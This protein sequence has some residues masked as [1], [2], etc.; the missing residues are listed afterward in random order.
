[1]LCIPDRYKTF[2]SS[3]KFIDLF[4]GIGG[5][6]ISLES[7][8][9][10][11]VFSSDINKHA[12]H[13]YKE[14]FGDEPSGDITKIDAKDIPRHD[15]ICGGFPCRPFSISGHM[16]GFEDPKEGTLFFEMLRIIRYHRPKIVLFE[17][18]K[19]LKFYDGGRTLETI[20]TLLNNEGY[21]VHY[22]MLNS[23]Y[24]GVPQTRQRIYIV[25]FHESFNVGKFSFPA[26]LEDFIVLR[27]ILDDIDTD[28][29]RSDVQIIRDL[30]VQ[31]ISKPVRVAIIGK[32]RQG[33]R[34]YHPNG[35]AITLSSSGGGVGGSS[36]L[37]LINDK[38][39]KLSPRECARIMGFPESF[40]LHKS[41]PRSMRQLGNSIV[42]DVLQYIIKEIIKSIK[43]E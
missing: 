31:P 18:V 38:I 5:F 40:K 41:G 6:R 22:N 30:N 25:G 7:F 12:R 32:S 39:R 35:H 43:V 42:I 24:Y 16:L 33:E 1:M 3:F 10:R 20:C 2:L 23:S 9:A 34:I 21:E 19:N 17:N 37:Y 11:C 36:G 8:G 28:I 13:T 14:N 29:N 15:I 27:D 4:S 26:P